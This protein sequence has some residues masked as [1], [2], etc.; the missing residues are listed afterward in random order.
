[1]WVSQEGRKMAPQPLSPVRRLKNRHTELS[2]VAQ[3]AGLAAQ[4]RRKMTPAFQC[5]SRHKQGASVGP[6]R[7]PQQG[8]ACD[9][10]DKEPRERGQPLH[11]FLALQCHT[12]PAIPWSV[13]VRMTR[14]E[15]WGLSLSFSGEVIRVSYFQKRE[16]CLHFE[17][18]P[19]NPGL[20]Q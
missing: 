3:T 5:L 20:D 6:L 12:E 8:C 4:G 1:M 10:S 14:T 2:T 9:P 19:Q 17:F 7:P 16:P 15:L 18:P 11:R 13:A